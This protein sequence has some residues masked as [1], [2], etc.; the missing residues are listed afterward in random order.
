MTED[1]GPYRLDELVGRGGMG[2]VWRAYDTRRK[3]VV[4]L[5]RLG[6]EQSGNAEFEARFRRE[7]ELAARLHAPTVIPIHDYGEIDGRLFL[8]MRFVQ[9]EDLAARLRHGPLAPAAA[10]R[11]VEQLA[12]A[13]DA[14]H[15]AGLVHRDVKPSNA[16]LTEGDFVYLVDF[17]IVRSLAS[18]TVLTTANGVVG[19]AGY[20]APERIL[21]AGEDHRS[22]VYSLACV[23]HECLTG[24]RPYTA[25]TAAA[26]LAAHVH[27]PV[28]RPSAADPRLRPFDAVVAA[29][30]AKDPADRP[31]SAGA[32]ARLAAQALRGHVPHTEVGLRRPDRTLRGGPDTV[33]PLAGVRPPGPPWGGGSGPPGFPGVF[34]DG[35]SNPPVA[36]RPRRSRLPWFAG[37]ALLLVAGLVTTL[38]VA[39]PW[40]STGGAEPIAVPT[41]GPPTAAPEPTLPRLLSRVALGGD[42]RSLVVDGTEA[43]VVTVPQRYTDQLVIVDLPSGTASPPYTVSEAG[44]GVG[45]DDLGQMWVPRCAPGGGV[46]GLDLIER[47]GKVI[48]GAPIDRVPTN[49]VLERRTGLAHV[50]QLGPGGLSSVVT[51]DTTRDAVIGG[52][53]P[54]GQ[55]N[56][57]LSLSPGGDTLAFADGASVVS[58]LDTRSGRA[59][60]AITAGEGSTHTAFSP[61]GSRLYVS[62]GLSGSVT[63]VDLDAATTGARPT[64]L[65]TGL[66][67]LA[68]SPDGTRLYVAD[69]DHGVVHV[70]DAVSMQV[71]GAV[72]VGGA[73]T[74]IAATGDRIHVLD[75][76][77]DALLTL[78]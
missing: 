26:V 18:D 64:A 67:G 13:L 1:F 44:G 14:A 32:F 2:E 40:G 49:M 71:I 8:D 57:T 63:A 50:V 65:Q 12:A 70:L 7:C 39:R 43:Y 30:M 48:A 61:D 62:S 76:A 41:I 4:A 58:L 25:T 78:G 16:L 20:L 6:P 69:T 59:T 75:T 37:L 23:L 53:Y 68:V 9:G 45:V 11:V 34:P 36:T 51:V 19:T 38:L 27:A 17:G 35:G 22:D 56:A 72:N 52:P 73:P 24:E 33:V 42:P 10:V 29:G 28:P 46:C 15:A 55:G 31:P 54:L 77:G 3:R 66:A 60:G 74:E 5:K 21:G 47:E